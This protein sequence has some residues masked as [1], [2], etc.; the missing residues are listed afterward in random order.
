[1]THISP[2]T[3]QEI[4]CVMK[5][6]DEI[7]LKRNNTLNPIIID[8]LKQ[9]KFNVLK[10]LT[11]QFEPQGFTTLILLSESHVA[12]HTYPEHDALYFSIYSCRGPDDSERTFQLLREKLNPREFTFLNSNK[13]PLLSE[14]RKIIISPIQKKKKNSNRQF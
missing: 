10:T 8:I 12:I 1:M 3:G 7:Y 6:V 9:E 5:G 4:S 11:Y 13:I 14:M 2:T